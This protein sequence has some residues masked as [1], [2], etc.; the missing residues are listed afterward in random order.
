MPSTRQ[1]FFAFIA[2]E[3]EIIGNAFGSIRPR[4]SP[5]AARRRTGSIN[6]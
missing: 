3:A 5:V 1:H 6:V 2:T 4:C